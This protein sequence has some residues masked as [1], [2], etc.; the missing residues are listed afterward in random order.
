MKEPCPRVNPPKEWR[1]RSELMTSHNQVST[2]PPPPFFFSP[3]GPRRR[4]PQQGTA[5][6]RRRTGGG[7]QTSTRFTSEKPNTHECSPLN[8]QN[9]VR[10]VREDSAIP[11]VLH[12]S[13]ATGWSFQDLV[14]LL[15]AC[16]RGWGWGAEKGGW[17]EPAGHDGRRGLGSRASSAVQYHTKAQRCEEEWTQREKN[18]QNKWKRS[19]VNF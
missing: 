7:W 16:D 6:E 19:P 11:P 5:S 18:P 9:R 1:N 13:S 15:A 17:G 3:V 10:D 2:P 4:I 14:P 12:Q 8:Q